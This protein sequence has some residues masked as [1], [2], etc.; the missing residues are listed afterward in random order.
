MNFV[1]RII[2][3]L[4]IGAAIFFLITGSTPDNLPKSSEEGFKVEVEDSGTVGEWKEKV[5]RIFTGDSTTT[6]SD[7]SGNG[8]DEVDVEF[9][10]KLVPSGSEETG[11]A[12]EEKTLEKKGFLQK[13]IDKFK[14]QLNKSEESEA[15]SVFSSKIDNVPSFTVVCFPE[16][17]QTCSPAGCEETSPKV[18]FTLLDEEESVIAHCDAEGCVTYEAE[19]ERNDGY[20]NYQPVKPKGYIISKEIKSDD[21]RSA[22]I[23]AIT[24][25]IEI[26]MYSGYCLERE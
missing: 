24:R 20:D 13:L 11:D 26:I 10:R 8:G 16:I 23:E 9:F 22:Y 7:A 15:A 1:L 17:K 19:Y 3:A 14:E 21:K 25:G 4:G 6:E 5:R 2:L 12:A 18:E